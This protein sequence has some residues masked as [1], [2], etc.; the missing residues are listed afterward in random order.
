M[1]NG[2]RVGSFVKVKHSQLGIGKIVRVLDHHEV[3]VEFFHSIAQQEQQVVFGS[4]ISRTYIEMQT[5]CYIFL[6]GENRWVTGRVKG[7][8]DGEYEVDF[9]DKNS[10]YVAERHLHVRC[11]APLEDPTEV[12]VEKG[13]ETAFFHI[14]RSRFYNTLLDQRAA[15][16]GMT[17]LVSSNIELLPHQVEVV[18]R[19][20]EDPI[21]RYLLADEVGLGKTIEA[22]I[23]LRQYLLDTQHDKVLLVVPGFL[24][25]QWQ[26]EMDT[27][28]G[29]AD[30]E[31]RVA[32][33][34]QERLHLAFENSPPSFGMVMVDEAHLLAAKLNS[35]VE[36]ERSEFE[37]LREISQATAG[38]LLL[39][40]TPVLNNEK[41]FL[42]MLH[43][44]DPETYSLNDMD[45]FKLRL[46]KRQE[47]GRF[48]LSFRED[49]PPVVLQR[50]LPRL[51]AMFPEDSILKEL[52]DKLESCLLEE[53]TDT[54]RIREL[55][56]QIRV[57]LSNTYRLHRRLLR[58]RREVLDDLFPY[59]RANS[60]TDIEFDMDVRIENVADLLEDWRESAWASERHNWEDPDV[61]TTDLMQVY[62]AMVETYGSSWRLLKEVLQARLT[63]KAS[64]QL[65]TDLGTA[66]GEALVSAPSFP[67]EELLLKNMID[68]LDQPSEDERL[69]V[70]LF[71]L[72]QLL[73]QTPTSKE[74]KKIVIFSQFPSVCREILEYLQKLMGAHAVTGCHGGVSR[75]LLEKNIAAFQE[76]AECLIMVCD[77]SIEAGRNLQFADVLIHFDVPFSPNR[78]EQRIGRLDRIGRTKPFRSYVFV[79][80]DHAHSFSYGWYEVLQ[81]GLKIFQTSVAS[82]QFFVD[83][84]LPA[85]HKAAYLSGVAGLHR[86]LDTLAGEIVEEQLKLSEQYA[87][88]GIDAREQ[89]ASDFFKSLFEHEATEE[90]IED[91]IN[92]WVVDTLDFSRISQGAKGD[93]FRYQAK[94]NKTLVPARYLSPLH[95]T[96][97]ETMT[98][99]RKLAASGSGSLLRIGHPFLEQLAAY[100][101]WDDR[102][103]AFAIWRQVPGWDTREGSEW[104]GFC[105]EFLVE[106]EIAEAEHVYQKRAIPYSSKALQRKMDRFFPP[107][108]EKIFLD[109]DGRPVEDPQLLEHL[110]K[111]FQEREYGGKDTNIIKDRLE[112]VEQII[113]SEYW[114]ATC[115]HTRDQAE[116]HLRMSDTMQSFCQETA[117]RAT[118]DLEMFRRNLAARSRVMELNPDISYGDLPDL[119]QEQEIQETLIRGILNPRFRLDSVGFFV[120][121]GRILKKDRVTA[122]G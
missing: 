1:G 75:D 111:P 47:V 79:G 9:P 2:V 6:E 30:Y 82:L 40:A 103:R 63:G 87:L 54:D 77:R 89:Q 88:D 117:R 13:Q 42:A 122:R 3:I 31:D 17:G 33:V 60:K 113:S 91:G 74:G 105:F 112:V 83:E 18:R 22:G 110:Q 84:K 41:E 37:T 23:I 29:F 46:E 96:S 48:L 53:P 56:Q 85:L 5:K 59:G 12:L 72:N 44:L 95:L 102:G 65:Q 25:D 58:N 116:R 50:A 68:A 55:I 71:R 35:N 109:L 52:A 21:Q 57:H 119:E 93:M 76:D 99:R 19:V 36:Q 73:K 78:L 34:E 11:Y 120:L 26:H 27:K 66:G 108:L 15:A 49:K 94:R 100:L 32:W 81:K 80:P 67:E 98:F 4:D 7:Y 106:G 107:R 118:A 28:F 62:L 115:Y 51:Q 16:R 45:S 121:S 101:D 10:C 104:A 69:E 8:V 92:S 64:A 24:L 61:K 114:P 20:L 14:H 43:L 97:S 90:T 86:V 38:L 70:L 39:S